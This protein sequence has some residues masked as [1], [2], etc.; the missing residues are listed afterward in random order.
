MYKVL[1]KQK[2]KKCDIYFFRDKAKPIKIQLKHE[3]MALSGDG[4]G[5]N[6]AADDD[7]QIDNDVNED[8]DQHNQSIWDDTDHSTDHTTNVNQLNNDSKKRAAPSNTSSSSSVSKKQRKHKRG[9]RGE[10]ATLDLSTSTK[11]CDF[12]FNLFTTVM[13]DK[14]TEIEKI[15]MYPTPA[16]FYGTPDLTEN[17]P[18]VIKRCITNCQT[19]LKKVFS[20]KP[21][22]SPAVLFVTGSSNRACAIIKELSKS[23]LKLP[24]AKLFSR[25]MK[26]NAQHDFLKKTAYPIGVG[27]PNRLLKLLDLGYLSLSK[28]TLVVLDLSN[29][30][31]GYNLMS[32]IDTRG[33]AAV[34]LQRH[35]LCNEKLQFVCM[36]A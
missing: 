31:K 30:V 25:H 8:D 7:I 27:T 12:L 4:L 20:E 18:T 11:S 36:S 5:Q 29:D 10:Q 32:Q 21:T 28:T 13:G 3:R 24:V 6:W 35:L 2:A 16:R 15:E 1:G 33:D 34:L 14:L 22:K 19:T 9:A 23:D 26:V 17:A